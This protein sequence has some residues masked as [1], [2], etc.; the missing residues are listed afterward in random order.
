MSGANNL[1]K[2]GETRPEWYLFPFGKPQ[3]TDPTRPVTTLKTVWAKKAATGLAGRWHDAQ[4]LLAYPNGRQTAGAGGAQRE[5]G[6]YS[7]GAGN[8]D[9]RPGFQRQKKEGFCFVGSPHWTYLKLLRC[10]LTGVYE[11]N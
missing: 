8:G 11:R 5:T 3:P 2:F 10:L 7:P 1:E 6:E 4:A 9:A